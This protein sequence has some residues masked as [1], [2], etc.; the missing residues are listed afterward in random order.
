[1]QAL[2]TWAC[3]VQC[4]TSIHHDFNLIIIIITGR[5][6][7]SLAKS[8]AKSEAKQTSALPLDQHDQNSELIPCHTNPSYGLSILPSPSPWPKVPK[9]T[10]RS[11]SAELQPDDAGWW[12]RKRAVEA[13]LVSFPPSPLFWG[14][15][16]PD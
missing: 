3:N 15:T 14:S 6:D 9:E 11:A 1:M 2:W 10:S 13:Q 4:N 5:S 7:R 16:T 12:N 8:E